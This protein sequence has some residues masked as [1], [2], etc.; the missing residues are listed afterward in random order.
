LFSVLAPG[1]RV[2]NAGRNILRSDG[3]KLVD[4][5]VIKNTRISE[6]VR[7]QLRADI[8]NSLNERNY[9]IPLSALNSG[10]NFLNEGSTDGGNRRII[11][12]ARLVF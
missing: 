7:F 8:F 5:G 9:G 12:G 10:A 2:G 4:F 11:I 1:Q 6:T 3:I